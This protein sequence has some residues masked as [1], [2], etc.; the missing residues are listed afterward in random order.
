[1]YKRILIV[2]DEGPVA[3]AALDE[4]LA[5]A[6]SQGAEVLFFHVL[7]NYVM[8][9]ADAPSL[10]LMSPEQHRAAVEQVAARLIEDAAEAA[11]AQGVS[12]SS[13]IGAD[14]DAAL[15][16]ARAAVERRCDL[17][18]VG[19]HGRNALQR[20]IF[21]SLVVRLIPV[22]T[23]PMLVCKAPE[24]A[25]GPRLHDHEPDELRFDPPDLPHVAPDASAGQQ[26]T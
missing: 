20:L 26:P 23:V 2:V 22:I 9:V 3:R 24:T 5:L 21:G 16:I 4:G 7:P 14:A 15:C 6:R 1:M 13:A 25:P 12:F 17:V 11:R 8:P 19:S 18:A 10:V